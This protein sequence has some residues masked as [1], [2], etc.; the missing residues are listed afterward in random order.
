MTADRKNGMW[1]GALCALVG[2]SAMLG[3][4]ATDSE[5]LTEGTY[6]VSS[7]DLGNCATNTWLKSSTTTT[8]IVVEANA[9]TYLVKACT[10]GVS[11]SPS[12][13]SSYVW[14][15]DAWRG[16]DGGAYL[17][18]SGCL[19]TFVDATARVVGDELVIEATRW[20]NQLAGGSC[21]YDEV[22]AMG[23][24]TCDSRTRIVAI[25]Q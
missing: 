14:S 1:H 4:C 23:D 15:E 17:Q 22:L 2:A 11:C 5:D 19:V 25:K 9:D 12:S 3:G 6:A 7:I 8:S 16:E 21:T 10:D 20:V 24:G 18:E 13:P